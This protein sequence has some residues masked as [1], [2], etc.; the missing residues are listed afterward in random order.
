[1]GRRKCVP[2]FSRLGVYLTGEGVYLIK[3]MSCYPPLHDVCPRTS[4]NLS[5]GEPSRL[6]ELA[7]L[8]GLARQKILTGLAGLGWLG[9][10]GCWAMSCCMGCLNRVGS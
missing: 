9:W 8:A 2:K 7:P 3:G 5:L 4:A 6:A 1:M 10:L